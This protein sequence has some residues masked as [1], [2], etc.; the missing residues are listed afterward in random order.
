MA[1]RY[2]STTGAGT[3]DGTSWD[4]RTPIFS[5]AGWGPVLTGFNFSG[6]GMLALVGPGTYA[7]TAAMSTATFSIAPIASGNLII[8]GCDS[9]GNPLSPPDPNWTADMPVWDDSNLPVFHTTTNIITF[10]A[11]PHTSFRLIKCTA[12][13][14]NSSVISYGVFNCLVDW[15][16]ITNGFNSTTAKGLIGVTSSSVIT[17]SIVRMTGAQYDYGIGASQFDIVNCQIIGNISATGGDRRGI[18]CTATTES[19]TAVNCL[20]KNHGGAGIGTSLSQAAEKFA[21]ISC[22]ITNNSG[23]GIQTG[24]QAGKTGRHIFLGNT[25]TNNGG[26]G[27]NS[28]ASSNIL[29][30]DNRLRDNVSGNFAGFLNFPT[31]IGNYATDSDDSSEYVDANAGDHR[32]K[33]GSTIWGSGYGVSEECPSAAASTVNIIDPLSRS[34]PG[35]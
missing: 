20:I 5:G 24:L 22:T 1:T 17:N 13:A 30:F 27:I 18:E 25:I 4:N 6:D 34:I 3:Q 16:S 23:D 28:Q 33:Y 21:V 8:H 31:G 35:V 26:Y 15:C 9:A 10:S 32:I 19:F 29:A 12:T 14:N 11:V 7:I 2:F